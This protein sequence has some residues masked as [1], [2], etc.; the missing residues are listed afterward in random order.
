MEQL[1]SSTDIPIALWQYHKIMWVLGENTVE[2]AKKE[3]FGGALD[4]KELY[5]DL[6]PKTLREV[7]PAYYAPYKV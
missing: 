3:E 7:A 2:N 1:L 4:A 6:T 5:P